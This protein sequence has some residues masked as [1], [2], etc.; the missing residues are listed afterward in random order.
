MF[1]SMFPKY[2]LKT[3]YRDIFP[4]RCDRKKRR[5]ECDHAETYAKTT[6]H[7]NPMFYLRVV[8]ALYSVIFEKPTNSFKY[9]EIFDSESYLNFAY[10]N[11]N[12]YCKF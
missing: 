7:E 12:K 9:F 8:V 3:F 5:K 2:V 1:L 11:S 6:A 10:L 4:K